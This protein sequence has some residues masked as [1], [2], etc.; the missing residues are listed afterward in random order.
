MRLKQRRCMGNN[1]HR[2]ALVVVRPRPDLVGG[3][4]QVGGRQVLRGKDAVHGLKRKLTPAVQEIGKMGLAK[5]GLAGQKETLSVPR[6]ILRSSSRRRRSCIWVKF[7]CGKSA[8]SN[9][10]DA[11][12]FSSGKAIRADWPHIFSALAANWKA[13]SGKRSG[14]D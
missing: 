11:S 1:R 4:Q 12:L 2:A 3:R 14:D 8:T 5:A 6:C 13:L 10:T 7:I 9:G